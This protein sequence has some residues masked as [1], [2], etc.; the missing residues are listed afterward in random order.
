MFSES[1]YRFC[2]K[3]K[4]TSWTSR[5]KRFLKSRCEAVLLFQ[6][7][8]TDGELRLLFLPGTYCEIVLYIQFLSALFPMQVAPLC[9]LEAICCG[10]YHYNFIWF[11]FFIG[12]PRLT[13]S[14]TEHFCLQS[15]LCLRWLEM[16]KVNVSF[17]FNSTGSRRQTLWNDSVMKSSPWTRR[18]I[19]GRREV[20]LVFCSNLLSG[21]RMRLGKNKTHA[22]RRPGWW[23]GYK[24]VVK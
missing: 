14:Y 7:I 24:T 21:N 4:E 8:F 18:A 15:I 6:N 9:S 16:G 1:I 23:N 13:L 17:F 2:L 10:L 5:A 22:E 19:I 11:A 3:K 12:E 20:E